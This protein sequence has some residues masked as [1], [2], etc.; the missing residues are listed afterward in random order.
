MSK[1][2]RRGRPKKG[3]PRNL[4]AEAIKKLETAKSKIHIYKKR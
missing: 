2:R 4:I 3:S 1:P